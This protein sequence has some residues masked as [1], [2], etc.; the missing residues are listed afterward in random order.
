M[1][2]PAGMAVTMAMR[3]LAG[4]AEATMGGATIRQATRAGHRFE[5]GAARPLSCKAHGNC[6]DRG[7]SH[8]RQHHTA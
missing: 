6:T 7:S 1:S 3:V 8:H 2:L 5:P 4:T